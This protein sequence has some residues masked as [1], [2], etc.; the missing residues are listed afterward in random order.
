LHPHLGQRPPFAGAGHTPA[1]WRG[2]WATPSQR[3]GVCP[4]LS[5]VREGHRQRRVYSVASVGGELLGGERTPE[6]R[7]YHPT[8]AGPLSPPGPLA[9]RQA[10]VLLA[11]VFDCID[12]LYVDDAGE[13]EDRR[14]HARPDL[15]THF[16]KSDPQASDGI[17]AG[18]AFSQHA[19]PYRASAR[20][21]ARP[22]AAGDRA[23]EL[24]HA[25]GLRPGI[26][27]G[28]GLGEGRCPQAAGDGAPLDAPPADAERCTEIRRIDR[29][30]GA[31]LA[32]DAPLRHDHR[33]GEFADV[34]FVRFLWYSDGEYG[35]PLERDP[36]TGL[37]EAV[38]PREP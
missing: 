2:A 8:R 1:P 3:D 27:I 18:L 17:A 28:I 35:M 37:V 9:A 19:E 24:S 13:S 16:V 11:K 32:L 7:M 5:L 34:E 26:W 20:T 14:E 10:D 31:T 6:S 4:T 22:A 21:L 36:R 25:R 23:V 15:Y 29:I 33:P 30:D 38:R 12:V